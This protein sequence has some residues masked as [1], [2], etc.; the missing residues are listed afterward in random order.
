M[1]KFS[2]SELS[3]YNT[4]YKGSCVFYQTS[5]HIPHRV[6]ANLPPAKHA[7]GVKEPRLS[8]WPAIGA[9]AKEANEQMPNAS[10]VLAPISFIRSVITATHAG[11]TGSRGDSQECT[12]KAWIATHIIA[13]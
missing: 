6:K 1:S 10:D 4:R 13:T 7:T 3:Y 8:S 5:T 12:S 11:L 2:P 9:P